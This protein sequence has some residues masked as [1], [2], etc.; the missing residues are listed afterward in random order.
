[1][2]YEQIYDEDFIR[3]CLS[4]KAFIR[5]SSD[6][7][8][9]D[10]RLMKIPIHAGII[11]LKA[12]SY[13]MFMGEKRNHVSYEVHTILMPNARGKAVKIA[14]GAMNWLFLNTGCLRVTTRVPSYNKLAQRLSLK[15]GMKLFGVDE[16]SFMKD[17]QLYDQFLYGLSKEEIC[18]Y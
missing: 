14:K 13:G 8:P 18:Q 11:W 4:D 10:V 12:G 5:A 7:T 6:D 1:M 17:G 16:K 15:T 3:L 9:V 2:R